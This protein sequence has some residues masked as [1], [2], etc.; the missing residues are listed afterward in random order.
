MKQSYEK[1]AVEVIQFA[2]SDIVT[3]SNCGKPGQGFA[4]VGKDGEE[5]E[6]PIDSLTPVQ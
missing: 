1:A 3:Y 2:N 6:P 5:Y 4:Y